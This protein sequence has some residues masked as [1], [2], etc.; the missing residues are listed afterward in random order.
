MAERPAGLRA[1]LFDLDGTLLDTLA[2]LADSM[3]A[4]LRGR[5]FPEH[6]RDSYRF[7]IGDGV[8]TLVRRAL[9]PPAAADPELA[10][11]AVLEYHREYSRRWDAATHPYAGIPELLAELARRGLP[12]AV[13]SNKP[14]RF[15]RT[16]TERFFPDIRFASVEG[17]RQDRPHKPDPT[18]AL[19]AARRMG[20]EAAEVLYVGD[21]SVDMLT[22][23]AAGMF[24]L[25]VSWGFR[26]RA[27]LLAHGARAIA[28]KP[29]D[30]LIYIESGA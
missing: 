4:V 17:Q 24:P 27:E 15:T 30:M 23:R 29:P 12:M 11:A 18:G 26:P 5:G 16:C 6:P 9:P 2:D 3:N 19:E 8:P 13:L 22:A 10:E 21:S 28:E 25:G 20:V 7:F 14:D 1:V